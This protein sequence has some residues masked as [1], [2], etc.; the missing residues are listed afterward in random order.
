MNFGWVVLSLCMRTQLVVWQVSDL[1]YWP[2]IECKFHS[3]RIKPNRNIYKKL[4]NYPSSY[5]SHNSYVKK[6]VIVMVETE[7]PQV[8]SVWLSF[9][10]DWQQ[11]SEFES[12]TLYASTAVYHTYC[13][14]FAWFKTTVFSFHIFKMCNWSGFQSGNDM[15]SYFH[16]RIYTLLTLQGRA[17][18]KKLYGQEIFFRNSTGRI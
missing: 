8:A 3:S 7:K 12:V 16:S 1:G 14:I 18:K 4:R 6:N 10:F 9:L 2:D 11:Q 15:Q 13:F 17:M 5:F